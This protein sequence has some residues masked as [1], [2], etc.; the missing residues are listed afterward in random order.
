MHD[1]VQE[2]LNS[3]EESRSIPLP[4]HVELWV[5]HRKKQI[6]SDIELLRQPRAYEHVLLEYVQR[7]Y[8]RR[9]ERADPLCTCPNRCP[10]KEGRLPAR[11]RTATSIDEG[12]RDYRQVH[13]GQ[14]LVLDEGYEAY[15][16]LVAHVVTELE[17]VHTAML[18]EEL[19][20]DADTDGLDVDIPETDAE[21]HTSSTDASEVEA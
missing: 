12:M 20:P 15:R 11:L 4:E 18:R 16:D 2:L 5:D 14:P 10:V 19:P 3:I 7:Q 8:E 21:G 1:R 6:R 9:Q 17:R 13:V